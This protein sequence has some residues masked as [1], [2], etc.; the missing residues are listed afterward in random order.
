MI[1]FSFYTLENCENS[2]YLAQDLGVPSCKPFPMLNL[3]CRMSASLGVAGV[4]PTEGYTE[5]E[6]ECMRSPAA[7]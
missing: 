7:P 3:R 6:R 4:I 2:H 1:I 5:H